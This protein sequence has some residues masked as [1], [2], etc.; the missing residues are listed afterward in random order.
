MRGDLRQAQERALSAQ[1]VAPTRRRAAAV[2]RNALF[3][4]CLVLAAC[5]RA[6]EL[7][8]LP[9]VDAKA[10]EPAVQASFSKAYADVERLTAAK[11]A[12]P[13]LAEAYGELA[14][15]YHVH[16]VAA[17][18]EAAYENARRLAPQD[19][20]WP[21]LLGHLY[22]DTAR[23]AEARKTFEAALAI[24]GR[25][26]PLVASLAAVSLQSG[27]TDRAAMLYEQLLT[28]KAARPLALNGLGKVAMAKRDYPKAIERFE[29]ALKLWPSATRLRAPLA[30]AYRSA[31]NVAKAEET[32]QGYSPAGLEPTVA[33]PLADLLDSKVASFR[34]LVKR[35]QRFGRAG[36]F[37]SAATAFQAAVA[38]KP[39]DPEALANLGISLAN[40]GRLDQAVEVL[41]K[42]LAIEPANALAQMSL[43]V[44]YD[45]QGKDSEARARYRATLEHDPK[46]V[47]ALVYLADL[48]MR[49]GRPGDAALRYQ[50]AL[51][52]APTPRVRIS[53]ALAHAAAGRYRDAKAT[54][55]QGLTAVPGHPAMTNALA[56]ILASAPDETVVDGARSLEIAKALFE[57]TRSPEVGQSYA[58]AMARTGDF[59]HAVK[60]QQETIIAYERMGVPQMKPFLERNL[61]AYRQNKPSREPWARDDP[62]FQP[63][64][65]AAARR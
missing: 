21:Y 49:G 8:P 33:D 32:L 53:L 16:D 4:C 45:R 29:E 17:A 36:E 42:S 37:E 3:A 41:E 28:D 6:P 51:E 44:L 60:L 27:D 15:R 38:I 25:D 23:P 1:A 55:E 11:E 26:V 22:N 18:A 20:R 39:S 47:D 24:D 40:L 64:S 63:R 34:G 2:V 19:K 56:R 54:L 5:G 59:E 7:L 65:P 12:N 50:Q 10:F 31:G 43:G 61:A 52:R 9:P 46:N 14:M 62:I 30:S 13:K 58:M 48:E 57:K 35:G